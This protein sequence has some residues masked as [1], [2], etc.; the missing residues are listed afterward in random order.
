MQ[1]EATSQYKYVYSSEMV[2]FVTASN[3]Y[4]HYL[5]QLQGEE[6]KSLIRTSLQLLADIYAGFLKLGETEPLVDTAMEPT[7]TEEDWSAIYQKVLHILGPYNDYLRPADEDEFDRSEMVQHTISEDLS[8]LYQE[9]KD[10]T[11]I[12]SRGLEEIM[13]DAAWELGERFSEHWGK[14]LLRATLALHELYIRGVDP[15]G[16]V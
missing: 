14:K 2:E 11:V 3:A 16:E 9:L 15:G 10:F 12:Y 4:C 7:V 8:D 5:E 1:H 6:G 13:N